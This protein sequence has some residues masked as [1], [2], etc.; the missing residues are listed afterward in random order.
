MR[1]LVTRFA[2]L[3]TVVSLATEAEPQSSVLLSRQMTPLLLC[4][5]QSHVFP[6][7]ALF[8]H[9]AQLVEYQHWHS[10]HLEMGNIDRMIDDNISDLWRLCNGGFLLAFHEI[11]NHN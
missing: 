11:F 10:L 1:A 6:I 7:H 8:T 4:L 9:S 3:T 5:L 2:V